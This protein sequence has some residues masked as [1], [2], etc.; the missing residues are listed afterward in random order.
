MGARHPSAK[1]MAVKGMKGRM[2][3]TVIA[4]VA[5]AGVDMAFV[6]RAALAPASTKS[7][8]PCLKKKKETKKRKLSSSSS[9]SSS[10]AEKASKADRKAEANQTEDRLMAEM[11]KMRAELARRTAEPTTPK[12]LIPGL[13]DTGNVAPKVK[14]EFC[15]S[16]G[17][18]CSQVCRQES[19][20]LILYA[21]FWFLRAVMAVMMDGASL[22]ELAQ[23]TVVSKAEPIRPPFL[24]PPRTVRQDHVFYD[25]H[26]PDVPEDAASGQT[27]LLRA[28]RLNEPEGDHMKPDLETNAGTEGRC[29]TH[30]WTASMSPLRCGGGS[31]GLGGLMEGIMQQLMPMITQLIQKAIAE[32]MGRGLDNESVQSP[33]KGEAKGEPRAKRQRGGDKSNKRK[34]PEEPGTTPNVNDV[35]RAPGPRGK[36]KGGTP[37]VSRKESE[38]FELRGQDW[39]CPLV[40]HSSIGVQ[41]DELQHGQTLEAVVL[42]PKQDLQKV[43]TILRGTSKPYRVMLVELNKDGKQRVPGRLGNTLTFRQA[44]VDTLFS[45]GKEA[46]RY[47]GTRATAVKVAPI[48]TVV[49][50]I[51]VPADFCAADKWKTFRANPTKAMATWAAEQKVVLM[52]SWG[53]LEETAHKQSRQ[54]FAKARLATKE[55]TSLLAASGCNGVFLDPPRQVQW[56]ARGPEEPDAAYLERGL[57]MADTGAQT[58]SRLTVLNQAFTEVVLIH[59]RRKGQKQK[60]ITPKESP[61]DS[62]LTRVQQPAAQDDTGKEI[63]AGQSRALSQRQIPDKCKLVEAAKVC[64][65]C[66]P[67]PEEPRLAPARKE[68]H[69]RAGCTSTTPFFPRPEGFHRENHHPRV[70]PKEWMLL[71]QKQCRESMIAKRYKRAQLNT[72]E[73]DQLRPIYFEA[74]RKALEEEP[75][76]PS[77]PTEEAMMADHQV[78]I[79]SFQEVDIHRQSAVGFANLWRQKHL[80]VSLGVP[81]QSDA[82]RSVVGVVAWPMQEAIA[83]AIAVYGGL[84]VVLGDFNCTQQEGAL[85]TSLM[86]GAACSADDSCDGPPMATNPVG[87]RRIDFAAM[88]PD[89]VARRE[90]TFRLASIS[91]VA[92]FAMTKT[93][94]AINHRGVGF[95]RD[96]RPISTSKRPL[97]SQ[98]QHRPWDRCLFNRTAG[99]LRRTRHLALPHLDLENPELAAAML[100]PVLTAHH[101]AHPRRCLER[102]RQK[103]TTSVEDAVTWVKHR[104]EQEFR[105]QSN[106]PLKEAEAYAVHPVTANAAQL[107]AGFLKTMAH[108]IAARMRRPRPEAIHRSDRFDQAAG[109]TCSQRKC[110][111]VTDT[112][113]CPWRLL[114]TARGYEV[115]SS[116]KF[117]GI[118]LDL[119]TAALPLLSC[120]L[121]SCRSGFGML[122]TCFQSGCANQGDSALFWAAGVAQPTAEALNHIRM[123]IVASLSGALTQEAPRILIGQVLGWTLDVHWMA[124]RSAL[125]Y[126]LRTL[127]S[128]QEWLEDIA[129]AKLNEPRTS[130]FPAAAHALQCFHWQLEPG[131]RCITRTH[132]EHRRRVFRIGVDSPS[133]L[134]QWLIEEYK[135]TTTTS[136]GRV[137]HKLHRN[138]PGLAVG[139]DLPKPCS[140]V[141]FAFEG[142]RKAYMQARRCG[143]ATRSIGHW[144]YW[145]ALPGKAPW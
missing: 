61:L 30:V 65:V 141:R 101:D 82:A 15:R 36:G 33:T 45:S 19:W 48:D 144:R 1:G 122:E 5:A 89:L 91:T 14:A 44:N 81:V 8:S 94:G 125:A 140:R 51:R 111:L 27:C 103:V 106:S 77:S 102:W 93:L 60:P 17:R 22:A 46:P 28:V 72:L 119:T 43:S 53:W 137:L 130:D 38:R 98:L 29:E 75:S 92:L 37:Q 97:A 42:A 110:H 23:L 63:S 11:H 123:K 124:D 71:L 99:S 39:D 142:H 26:F 116:L 69:C 68:G 104:A 90:H 66:G 13:W 74:A 24:K 83:H 139:L 7:K 78:S 86:C 25:E 59:H 100:E 107:V 132:D 127:T 73:K 84:F 12:R 4:P 21:N 115:V 117:L 120:A 35:P 145:V 55:V 3:I 135:L 40:A 85:S 32:A 87:T 20:V 112:H 2:V 9:S 49:I 67:F 52:D 41:L 133:V 16:G 76:L 6:T 134:K 31:I 114:A 105:L 126:L 47:A 95:S 54:L 56:L 109:L 62:K 138:T 128:P 131:N 57:R 136:C 121:K 64:K 118:E 129:I 79:A 10:P 143:T 50:T 113:E 96:Y 58:T 34:T 88:H 18:G 70:T 108:H 80:H